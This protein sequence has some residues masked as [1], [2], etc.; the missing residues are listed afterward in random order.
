[1]GISCSSTPAT[2]TLSSTLQPVTIE[3]QT[4]GFA[5]GKMMPKFRRDTLLWAECL[6][7]PTLLF[8]CAGLGKRLSSRKA[9]A[10]YG[11][12][13]LA[14]GLLLQLVSCGG[15]FTMPSKALPSATPAVRYQVTV[16]DNPVSSSPVTGFVQISLIVPLTVSATQ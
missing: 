13:V 9:L 10:R 4:A 16:V 6:P 2:V 12:Q 7:L 8:W 14:V 15:G 5:T 1:V 11:A 3:I